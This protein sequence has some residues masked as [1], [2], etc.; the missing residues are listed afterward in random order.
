MA[1]KQNKRK[2]IKDNG[3]SNCNFSHLTKDQRVKLF[4]CLEQN[5]QEKDIA[6][7]LG[8]S[9]GTIC[10][11]LKRNKSPAEAPRKLHKC[12]K[13]YECRKQHLCKERCDLHCRDCHFGVNCNLICPD[14]E[15]KEC[16]RLKRFPYVC[17]G[18]KEKK[19]CEI[20]QYYYRPEQAQT[21]ADNLLVTSRQGL[22]ISE[23]EFNSLDKEVSA[24]TKK[25]QSIEHVMTYS[26]IDLSSRT[27]RRYISSGLMSVSGDEL[28]AKKYKKRVRNLS[29]TER[30]EI[31]KAKEG[32]YLQDYM[33]FRDNNPFVSLIQMDTVEGIHDGVEQPYILTFINPI[34]RL[35]LAYRISNQTVACTTNVINNLYKILGPEDFHFLFQCII[36]D[37]GHEFSNPKQIEEDPQTGAQRTRVFYCDPYSSW[38]KGSIEVCHRLLR[39][40]LPKKTSF[41]KLTDEDMLLISSH[42]NSYTREENNG[43][44][45]FDTFVNA[46]G[47]RGKRILDKLKIRKIDA[48]DVMLTPDLLNLISRS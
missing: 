24:G 25:G 16:R 19:K 7:T 10:R 22:D 34:C 6:A 31:N 43:V 30:K 42:I 46:Y 40:I 5:M 48:K 17:N 13:Y 27:V 28:I 2:S 11:E 29:K 38:E 35:F 41:E 37:N 44:C 26:D 12:V 45:S 18:C 32:H 1:T 15:N 21:F 8:V 33:K 9:A 47:N 36:T 14:F 4:E 39:R 23:A 3:Q 20:M